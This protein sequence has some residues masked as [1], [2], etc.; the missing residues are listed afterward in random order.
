M[1]D[2]LFYL[3]SHLSYFE[4]GRPSLP[5][6]PPLFLAHLP[7]PLMS[8]RQQ[9][10]DT[11]WQQPHKSAKPPSVCSQTLGE[12]SACVEPGTTNWI[13]LWATG[14][15]KPPRVV[16]MTVCYE[17]TDD[18]AE[19]PRCPR[20]CR[21]GLWGGV[22]RIKRGWW[23]HVRRFIQ[24]DLASQV[25]GCAAELLSESKCETSD[26]QLGG[27]LGETTQQGT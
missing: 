14:K 20:W 22:V 6:S 17:P 10:G 5:V 3:I 13:K 4:G 7:R 11:S 21:C 1:S 9:S 26:D 12:T 18:A 15:K 25:F 8:A 19:L 16:T 23:R 24:K 2:V 27:K